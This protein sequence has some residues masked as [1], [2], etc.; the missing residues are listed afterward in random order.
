MDLI[1]EIVERD[2]STTTDEFPEP[3]LGSSGFPD[4][5]IFAGKRQFRHAKVSS[6][7][8]SNPLPPSQSID[9]ENRQRIASMSPQDIELAQREISETFSPHLLQGLL[10]RRQKQETKKQAGGCHENTHHEHAEGFNGWIGGVRTQ[11]GVSDLSQLSPSKITEALKLNDEPKNTQ[12]HK[13]VAFADTRDII[14]EEPTNGVQDDEVAPEE[15]QINPE[16]E[17]DD[18]DDD[19]VGVH[20]PRPESSTQPLD[21]NDPD[22]Y[23]KLHEKYYPD[24]PK[25]TE[26][27]S[28]MTTPLPKQMETTYESI[29]D[30]RFDF[31]GNLVQLRVLEEEKKIEMKNQD[32]KPCGPDEIPTY[33]GLH[34][35][36]DN[37]HMAGYT[38]AELV[39]LSRSVL[40]GQRCISIQILG[41]ILHKLG[42]HKYNFLPIEEKDLQEEQPATHGFDEST[43]DMIHAFEQMMWDLV[44]ELRVIDSIS[45]AADEN[46]TRNLSVKSY[47][48]EA[49]W[50]W[51]QGGGR[52]PREL[53]EDMIAQAV[54]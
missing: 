47:A 2:V 39:H 30:M 29:S 17:D 49:L 7:P 50:L 48:T 26:K 16:T 35:H 21:I 36:S 24:L 25:E 52:P 53:E 1:G 28:W 12:P 8:S 33:K 13:T 3:P 46:R 20:F 38:L 37:P 45:D 43:R 42:K 51:R 31:Q 11:D 27:L 32:Q 9:E 15:Y 19:T 5:K 4:L 23:D 34:H 44:D 40:P 18:D 6:T 14:S 54:N 22:F 10:K 41:R